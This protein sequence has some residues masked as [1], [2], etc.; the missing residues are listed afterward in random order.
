MGN[1][2]H[3]KKR[4]KLIF[5]AVFC[6]TTFSAIVGCSHAQ[7]TNETV[8]EKPQEPT[9][10]LDKTSSQVMQALALAKQNKDYRLWVTTSR[11]ATVP[12]I[13]PSEFNL[14]IEL[15]GKQYMPKTGDV[16]RTEQ[17]R[18]ERKKAIAYMQQYNEKM[19]TICENDKN[20]SGK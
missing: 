12:G 1:I 4:I 2:S 7:K 18:E 17:E 11:S 10:V 3:C 14:A 20:T 9:Q 6:I 15:C 16:I 19:W 13:K 8:V 5:S